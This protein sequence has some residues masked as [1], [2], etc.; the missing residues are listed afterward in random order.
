MAA[1][2][3]WSTTLAVE[4]ILSVSVDVPVRSSDGASHVPWDAG[5]TSV[6]TAAEDNRSDLVNQL[7]KGG[8]VIYL[9]PRQ[10]VECSIAI[11]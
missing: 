10:Q 1:P 5:G 3:F 8:K 2:D 4:T 11:V 9:R 6:V 7:I